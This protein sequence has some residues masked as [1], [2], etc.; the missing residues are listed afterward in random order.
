[1]GKIVLFDKKKNC[2]A[3]GACLNICPKQAIKMIE[4][5]YGYMYPKIDEDLC[6]EC[7]ECKRVC[8]FQ[9]DSCGNNPIKSFA[10]VNKNKEQLLKSTSGGIFAAVATKVLKDGGVVFGATLSFQNGHAI[11]QHI[12]IEELS[13]ISLLQGSKY[14]Q[15]NIGSS[16]QKAQAY[17]KQNRQVL[18][19]GTP[20]Q[21]AGLYGFLKNDYDNLITI[22]LICHGVPNAAFFDD[23]IQTEKDK[24]KAAQ[25]VGYAFRDK[26][27]GWGMIGR[28]DLKRINGKVQS[29]NIP[30]KL[31]S[32]N[33][34]FLGGYTYRECCYVCKYA[35]SQRFGDLTIGDYWGIENEHPEILGKNGYD[36]KNGISCVLANTLKGVQIC[37]DLDKLV[38]M[39]QSSL[40]KIKKRNAQ[41]S[42]PSPK[43]PSR[44][45][46]L[47][48]YRN[49]GYV[50]V[51]SYFQKKFRKQIIVSR[52]YYAIPRSIRIKLKKMLK[53]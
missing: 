10:A 1:M 48:L 37:N 21:I 20:C 26:K 4:D 31:S 40:E 32:Y 5:E 2:C 50:A 47:E 43:V 53:G 24:R 22:D 3:C 8:T 15:S 27:T 14:V 28:L 7:G 16:Y 35:C 18:F 25:I 23:Y 29:V 17:L 34:L 12:A 9:N 36:E 42:Y 52:I 38:R 44:E 51:E 45:K 30:S 41:L 49:S 19:S 11:P 46:I 33:A 39:D 6:V 13:D